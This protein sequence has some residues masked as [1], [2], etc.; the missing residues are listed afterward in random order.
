MK[1][2]GDDQL[3]TGTKVVLN[4]I[5]KELDTT[6]EVIE[7]D[8]TRL[9]TTIQVSDDSLEIIWDDLKLPERFNWKV[10]PKGMEY[11][12]GQEA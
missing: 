1:I 9:R 11:L 3:H 5:A 7:E 4:K 2:Y 10:T 12:R 6:V 8:L